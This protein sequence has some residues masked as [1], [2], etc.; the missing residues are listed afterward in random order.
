M[1]SK[2]IRRRAFAGVIA[3]AVAGLSAVQAQT[4]TTNVAW[5]SI[6]NF[7][8]VNQ[9]GEDCHGFE[10]EL[11]DCDS[12]DI[13]YTYDWNHYGTPKIYTDTLT[14]PGHTNCFI[15]YAAVWTNGGWSA[16]TAVPT[17]AIAPTDGHMFT[18]PSTNFGGEHFG[19]GFGLQPSKIIYNWLV[20]DG[21]GTGAL[22]YGGQVLVSTPTFTLYPNAQIQAAMPAPAP[23]EF[24]REYGDA[25]WVKEIKTTVHTNKPVG[26]RD[27]QTPDSD[28]PGKKD[29]RN[30]E[31]DEVEIEWSLLQPSLAG[32]GNEELAAAK[33]AVNK[34]HE[35]VTRRWEFY[36]YVGGY[37]PENHEV[38][39][40]N[41]G[42]DGLHGTGSYS[43]T[44]VVGDFL[45]SQMSAADV[46][47]PLGLI[48]H[49]QDGEVNVDYTPRKMII[50]GTTNFTATLTGDLPDGLDFDTETGVLSGMPATPGVY[51]FTVSVSSGTNAPISKNYPIWIADEGEILPPHSAVDVSV[52]VAS[53]G[54]AD[55]NAV[56]VNG[57]LGIVAAEP[58]PG[59]K[60]ANWTENG[61]VVS[62]DS[63][64][65]FTN[66][67]NQ[68][69]TANFVANPNP[70]LE[71]QPA[72][73][74]Q[75]T[76]TWPTNYTGFT[77][78]Q[79]GSLFS[80]NW[81]NTSE[82]VSTVG[83]HYQAT[84]TATNGPRYF[85]LRHP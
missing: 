39:T 22:T 35:V 76:I 82:P 5:G 74:N 34:G 15:R 64:Y 44:V 77:L 45:G 84:I 57:D 31:P 47:S 4:T 14:N 49:V 38:N 19:V 16:Y 50:S 68:S 13:S 25:V 54:V 83:A 6:N 3:L 55:G 9:T 40:D 7:D 17:G 58:K 48:D 75:F 27:L 61:A 52:S 36:D 11:D 80:T 23:P 60:F 85:R 21:T 53:R 10:I 71:M 46:S 32:G 63:V 67:V 66:I 51:V 73:G 33:E 43:N 30:G 28:H 56:Y 65:V 26:L 81:V 72:V 59:Y 12:T 37:D 42:A 20:D 29:W 8:V 2:N 24:Y 41:V 79:I 70:P 62:T 1:H 78:Q 18:D 69:L